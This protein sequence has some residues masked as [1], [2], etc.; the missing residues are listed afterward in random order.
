MPEIVSNTTPIISLLKLSKLEI[1]KDLYSEIII[2]KAVYE[3]VQL[4]RNKPYYIDLKQFAWI[5]IFEVADRNSLKFFHDL[6]AGEAEAIVLAKEINAQL[7]I[8]DEKLGRY[9]ASNAGLKITG[10]LGVLIKAK[11][12]GFIEQVKPL[13]IEL[14]QKDVW[15]SE[16]LI[17]EVCK[18]TNE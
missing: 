6:D 2:P 1:L 12:A 15:I 8:I 5:Q 18:L 7:L 13:L 17:A 16:N 14:S 4:G 9:Y 10:T 11:N 3:E